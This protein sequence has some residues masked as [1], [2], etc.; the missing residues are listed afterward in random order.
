MV[1]YY[2]LLLVI[3]NDVCAQS[4]EEM[5]FSSLV[6]VLGAFLVATIFGGIASENAAVNDKKR[7]QE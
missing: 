4:P 2:A 1:S 5:T 7:E 6:L 3:G